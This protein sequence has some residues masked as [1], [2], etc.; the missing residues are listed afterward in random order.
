MPLA[1]LLAVSAGFLFALAL[2]MQRTGLGEMDEL[3]GS[4]VSI[5]AT[6]LVF[7]LGAPF[8]IDWAWFA[9]PETLVFAAV[10]LM[11]PAIGQRLQVASVRRVG[12]ALTAAFGS[13]TPFFAVAL[14]ILFLGERLSLLGGLGIAL[15]SSGL[16]LAALGPSTFRGGWPAAALLL[17]LGASLIRGIQQPATKGGLETL[18]SAYFA[19]LVMC[20]VSTLVLGAL[21]A[22]GRR[23]SAKNSLRGGAIFALSGITNGIGIQALN[24]A[25]GL[26]AVTLVAPLASTAPLW[27]L[28]LG[29][30]IFRNEALGRRHL[31]VALLV[32]LGTALV[33]APAP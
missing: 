16:V 1:A 9:R 14:A 29:A 3:T 15:L 12:P 4:F 18:P 8:L 11:F 21:W 19:T 22:W 32:F 13:F 2:Q 26:G 6:A 5:A 10:G 28:A 23:R 30:L 27:T 31:A 33:V 20:T 17:P 25:I 7:W 24:G